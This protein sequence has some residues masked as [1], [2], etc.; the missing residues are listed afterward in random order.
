MTNEM[1]RLRAVSKKYTVDDRIVTVFD[2]LDL[3]I[4]PN[5]ITVL[6]GKSGCGKTTLLRMLAG[7]EKPTSG[8]IDIP[9]SLRIGMVFQEPRLMPWLTCEK[10]VTLGM[11]NPSKEDSDNIL[12]LV[13]LEGFE[14]AYPSQLSGGMKQRAALAR[15][16]IRDSNLILMDEPFAALDNY[17]RQAMQKELLR[18]RRETNAG[19]VFVTHDMTEAINIGDR[20]ISIRDNNTEEVQYEKESN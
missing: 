16:L 8:S 12:K 6:I 2:E 18:I 9:D 14:R 7:L 11:K 1:I 15:T 10:N 13:G 17:T 19:I 5:E 4:N 3:D 20:I